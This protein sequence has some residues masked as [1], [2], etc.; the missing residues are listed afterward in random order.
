MA[1]MSDFLDVCT[2]EFIKV[3][4]KFFPILNRNI[5]IKI[6]FSTCLHRILS[7]SW[8]CKLRPSPM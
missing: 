3:E 5:F 6:F 1:F 2:G 8:I 7:S 4:A